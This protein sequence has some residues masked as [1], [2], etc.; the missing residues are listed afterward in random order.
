MPWGTGTLSVEEHNAL[1]RGVVKQPEVEILRIEKGTT[2]SGKA[3][4]GYNMPELLDMVKGAEE[5]G[6]DALVIICHGEPGV[7][8]ARALVRSMPVLGTFRVA[9]HIGLTLGHKVG[10]ITANRRTKS[11]NQYT[12][13]A[14]GL[15]CCASV[16][17][18]NIHA[19]EVR[20]QYLEYRDTGKEVELIGRAVEAGI[21]L[22]EED[23]ATVLAIGCGSLMWFADTIRDRLTEKGHDVPFINPLPL[24]V[25]IAKALVNQKLTHSPL[26]YS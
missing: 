24:T 3:L 9:L 5:D 4:V 22:I 10:V 14:C 12:I 1:L 17:S 16:R 15:D 26:F 20:S 21:R 13:R 2:A 18:L 6:F 19:S 23:E 11:D 25:E 7:E 8:E